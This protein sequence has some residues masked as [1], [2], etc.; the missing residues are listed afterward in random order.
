MYLPLLRGSA[1]VKSNSRWLD[2]LVISQLAIATEG[3][4]R[5]TVE[6]WLVSLFTPGGNTIRQA[7][8]LDKLH[9]RRVLR[10]EQRIWRSTGHNFAEV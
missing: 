2:G 10:L 6:A 3:Q 7:R 9:G 1:G 4:V 8:S 5:R